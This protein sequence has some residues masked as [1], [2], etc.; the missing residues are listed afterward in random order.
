MLNEENVDNDFDFVRMVLRLFKVVTLG[1]MK[2]YAQPKTTLN[3]GRI[4]I[5]L[6]KIKK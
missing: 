4:V 2:Q 6:L 3:E 1:I 5:E